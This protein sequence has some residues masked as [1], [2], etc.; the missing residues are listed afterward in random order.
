NGNLRATIFPELEIETELL[1]FGVESLNNEKVLELEIKC[2]GYRRACIFGFNI[3]SDTLVF[4]V[5]ND[6]SYDRPVY[7]E[8]GEILKLMVMFKPNNEDTYNSKLHILYDGPDDKSITILGQGVKSKSRI[9]FS[10]Q[11]IIFQNSTK[12]ETQ[13]LNINRVGYEPIEIIDISL[14]NDNGVFEISKNIETPLEIN[15]YGLSVFIDL[16]ATDNGYYTNN[17][18][19]IS[20]DYALPKA[21]I[22][23][24]AQIG[25]ISSVSNF[26]EYLEFSFQSIDEGSYVTF[27]IVSGSTLE[28]GTFSIYTQDGKLIKSEEVNGNNTEFS[29]TISKSELPSLSLIRFTQG[30]KTYVHKYMRE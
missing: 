26:S 13:K 15:D 28:L 16:L 10:S 22:P 29:V 11:E 19:V 25:T 14:E 17:I 8:P 7:L 21:I 23:I 5:L 30:K 20:S 4:S 1:D 2:V 18:I 3:K 27:S 9:R 6:I 12:N 24:Q